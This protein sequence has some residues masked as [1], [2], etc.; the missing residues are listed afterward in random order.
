[1][2]NEAV[3]YIY[4]HHDGVQFSDEEVS[5]YEKSW[6]TSQKI[7]ASLLEHKKSIKSHKMRDMISLNEARRITSLLSKPLADIS[8][9]IETNINALNEKQAELK[10]LDL[11]QD[12]IKSQIFLP[13]FYIEVEPLDFPRTVCTARK[14]VVTQPIG[15]T[16]ILQ[17]IYVRHCHE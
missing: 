3:R 15:N 4:A 12:G 10:S 9:T 11:T 13:Q 14:C 16:N 7:T 8:R 6:N 5:G 17:D 2:D 1:M